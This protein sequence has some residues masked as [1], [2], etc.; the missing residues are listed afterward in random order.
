[1]DIIEA[2]YPSLSAQENMR[3]TSAAQKVSPQLSTSEPAEKMIP[4]DKTVISAE[5]KS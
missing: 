4:I 3:D 2:R 5:G 1:M